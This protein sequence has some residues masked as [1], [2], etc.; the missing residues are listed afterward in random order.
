M[1]GS[2]DGF[3][4][5]IRGKLRI[6]LAH[7]GVINCRICGYVKKNTSKM[8]FMGHA[9]YRLGV[10]G[11]TE[12]DVRHWYFRKQSSTSRYV[13][14]VTYPGGGFDVTAFH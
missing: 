4:I 9:G 7:C 8:A 14:I 12:H 5:Y 11:N 3:I 6:L 2:G 1:G 13:D 10:S